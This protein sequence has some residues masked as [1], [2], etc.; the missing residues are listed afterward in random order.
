MDKKKHVILGVHI[1]DRVQAVPDVQKVFTEYGCYI[2]TRVGLH[3]VDGKVC[4]PGGLVILD[5]I[6]EEPVCCEMEQKLKAI[7][8][9]DVQKMTFDH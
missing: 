2:R 1:T 9:I 4:A 8:G 6:C 5:L 3:D 7:A